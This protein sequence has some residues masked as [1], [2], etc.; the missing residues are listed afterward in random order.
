M[1]ALYTAE[2]TATEAGRSGHVRSSDGF[3][4]QELAV[5]K[6]LGGPG[7]ATNPEQLFAA[8]YAACF[9]SALQLVARRENLVV[10]DSIVHARVGIGP[11]PKGFKLK[12]SLTVEMP[13]VEREQAERLV[14]K[15]HEVCPYSN[16]IE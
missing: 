6:K 15:A 8:G 13:G 16:A 4:D 9:N 10:T 2:A 14:A 3:I 5:P 11:H 1:I 12:V 7:G